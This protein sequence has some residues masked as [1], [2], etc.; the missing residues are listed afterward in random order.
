MVSGFRLKFICMEVT[1]NF[2]EK[3]WVHQEGLH[4]VNIHACPEYCVLGLFHSNSFHTRG[5]AISKPRSYIDVWK[6]FVLSSILHKA[7]FLVYL[8]LTDPNVCSDFHGLNEPRSIITC[9]PGRVTLSL[10]EDDF[11]IMWTSTRDDYESETLGSKPLYAGCRLKI[12]VPVGWAL[13]INN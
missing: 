8:C 13:N 12:T 5:H 9:M 6:M 1:I 3:R 4:N 10:R 2:C 7:T 11:F